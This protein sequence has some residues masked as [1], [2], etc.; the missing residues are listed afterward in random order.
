MSSGMAGVVIIEGD[1]DDVP[2]IA[3]ATE[4]VLLLNEVL[5]DFRGAIE[6]Y[7]TV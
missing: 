5:F 2:E 7:D 4:R 1:F 3:A 6:S